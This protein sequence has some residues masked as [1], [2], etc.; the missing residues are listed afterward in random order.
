V[1]SKSETV[2]D[3]SHQ[4][5]DDDASDDDVTSQLLTASAPPA[6]DPNLR[7]SSSLG[8]LQLECVPEDSTEL[9]EEAEVDSAADE[10]NDGQEVSAAA[11]HESSTATADDDGV[12][13]LVPEKCTSASLPHTDNA[14][15]SLHVESKPFL[16]FVELLASSQLTIVFTNCLPCDAMLARRMLSSCIC[17]SVRPSHTSIVPKW[18]NIE[19][20][21]QRHTLVFCCRRTL[22]NSNGINGITSNK[23]A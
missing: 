3:T 20:R 1:S 4:A 6:Y 2:I 16:Y 7:L 9:E 8:H 19:S 13:Q 15:T 5:N 14:D 10:V 11:A 18:L 22:R 17:L 23:G 12:Q 21:K